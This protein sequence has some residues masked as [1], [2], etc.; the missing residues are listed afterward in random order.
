MSR[1]PNPPL[2][3]TQPQDRRAIASLV[4]MYYAA[5]ELIV[6]GEVPRRAIASDLRPEQ[7]PERRGPPRGEALMAHCR[8]VEISLRQKTG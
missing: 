6:E 4:Q 3:R 1:N 7:R 5:A 8:G 2:D